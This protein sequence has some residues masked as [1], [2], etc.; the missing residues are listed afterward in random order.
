MYAYYYG[1][2]VRRYRVHC[3]TLS[4]WTSGFLSLVAF[5]L[6]LGINNYATSYATQQ[7][8]NPVT[9]IIL[10]NIPAFDVDGYF[11][12]GAALLIVFIVF[13][14][15][16]NPKQLPFTLYSLAIF[17]FVR[18]IFI[19]LTHL[20]PFPTQTPIEFS[21]NIG[22]FLSGVFFGGDD[23]FFSA[24]T[25]APFL[26]ALVFW[27]QPLLRYI[28][29]AWSVFFAVIVLLGHIHYTIDVASAFFISFGVFHI[30]MWLFSRAHRLFLAET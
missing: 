29:L 3:S 1:E 25:G 30:T 24:H 8:S 2:I 14:L 9:D 10:S 12:Y 21:T 5:V 6:A 4:F 16:T 20:G 26:M 28:F 19:S 13:V 22:Q 11:V 15:I 27:R 18:A 17:Y 7:A 23:L